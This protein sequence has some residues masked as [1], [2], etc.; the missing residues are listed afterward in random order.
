MATISVSAADKQL[1]Q[2]IETAQT[3]AVFVE[4]RGRRVA[5]LVSPE[6]YDELMEALEDAQ[7]AAAF[8]A[9]MRDGGPNVPWERFEADLG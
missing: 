6:R 3:Q 4:R 9:A 1:A 5:V 8:G 2:A 7:D